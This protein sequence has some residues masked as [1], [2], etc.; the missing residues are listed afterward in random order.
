MVVVSDTA[1]SSPYESVLVNGA[2]REVTLTAQYE[3]VVRF[4]FIGKNKQNGGSNITA[5]NIAK[6]FET[7]MR[8]AGTR[9][10]FAD[11]GLSVVRVGSLKQIPVMRDNAIYTNTSIDIVFGYEH[12]TKDVYDTIDEVEVTGTYQ[13][14]YVPAFSHGYGMVTTATIEDYNVSLTL[15]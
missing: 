14:T 7:K 12:I 1:M 5:A 10:K 11:N 15:P 2:T 6:T 3:A 8:F 13:F 4:Q 9:L